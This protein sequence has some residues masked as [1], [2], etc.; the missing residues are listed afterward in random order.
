M[1]NPAIQREL[2]VIDTMMSIHARLSQV[3]HRRYVALNVFVLGGSV[4]LN[5]L[6]FFSDGTLDAW[7]RGVSAAMFFLSLLP[8]V[9][10]WEKQSGEHANACKQLAVLKD[11]GR[12]LGATQFEVDQFRRS[13][14][15]LMGSLTPIPEDQFLSLKARHTR[16]VA[17]S[18][19]ISQHPGVPVW[20]LHWR[21]VK[22]NTSAIMRNP[23]PLDKS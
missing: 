7:L 5:G 16:K 3:L 22:E 10:H 23:K 21:L 6:L 15:E 1:A 8:F 20:I 9:V 18:R 17:L 2:D 4:A 19:L 13:Y 14:T 12:H 11:R